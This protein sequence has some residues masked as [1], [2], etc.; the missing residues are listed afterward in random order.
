MKQDIV[1]IFEQIMASLDRAAQGT[2]GH[3]QSLADM[4]AELHKEFATAVEEEEKKVK[5]EEEIHPLLVKKAEQYD[6]LQEEVKKNGFSSL[7]E[8]VKQSSDLR[9]EYDDLRTRCAQMMEHLSQGVE[10][11][12]GKK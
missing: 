2:R 12:L 5:T 8:L 9:K 1:A 10:I 7:E 11:L 4:F 3:S 6:A